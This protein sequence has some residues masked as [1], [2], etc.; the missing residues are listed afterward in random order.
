MI[1][2]GTKIL[3]FRKGVAS[4]KNSRELC[5]LYTRDK[6]KPYIRFSTLR[7]VCRI[8][9]KIQFPLYLL[10]KPSVTVCQREMLPTCK[11]LIHRLKNQICMVK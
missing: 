4:V 1:W 2:G 8:P 9:E 6:N 5:G 7:G 3:F 10:P 11:K